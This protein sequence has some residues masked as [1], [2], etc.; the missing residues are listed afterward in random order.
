MHISYDDAIVLSMSETRLIVYMA[1][2]VNGYIADCDGETPWTTAEWNGFKEKVNE[3]GDVLV[4]RKTYELMKKNG[5][6]VRIPYKKLFVLTS[7][8]NKFRDNAV[9]FVSSINEALE[10]LAKGSPTQL[11]IAGGT[12]ANTAAL[13]TGLVDEI[14]LDIEPILFGNGLPL[15]KLADY[16]QRL[17]LINLIRYGNSGVQLHYEVLK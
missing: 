5:T 16:T 4:G 10:I 14:I 12:G 1:T 7:S 2:S 6:L 3:V 13:E 11:L 9:V 8:K 17:E 15:F